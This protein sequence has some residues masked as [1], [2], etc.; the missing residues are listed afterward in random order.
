M[1]TD[2]QSVTVNAVAVPLPRV[3]TNGRTSIY[4]NASGDLT[5]TLAHSNGKRSRSVVRLDRQKTA[6][7]PLNPANFRPYS[8]SKYLVCDSPL[9]IGFTDLELQY[10]ILALTGLVNGT[11]WLAKF[12]GQES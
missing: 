4:E 9:N 11:G 5:L 1:F 7:D 3:S 6:A 10:D 8:T 2:P 12:L